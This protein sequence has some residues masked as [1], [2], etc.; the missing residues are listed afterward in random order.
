MKRLLIP[1][2]VLAASL[3]IAACGG[4]SSSDSGAPPAA[5]PP[6][7]GTVAV[8]SV[9]GTGNVL[10]DSSGKALY[11]ADVERNGKVLCTGACTSFWMP[12]TTDSAKPTGSSSAGTL[13]VVKRPDGTMQVTAGGRPLYTFSQDS[14]GKVT[15]N[16]FAD[17]FNGHHFKWTVVTAGGKAAATSGGGGGGSGPYGY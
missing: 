1:L 9:S 10:V 8:K 15:G 16:G 13:G 5:T 2:P 11:S 6:S 17:A 7:G 3:L 14:A 12:L 4:G